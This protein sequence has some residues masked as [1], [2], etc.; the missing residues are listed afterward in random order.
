MLLFGYQWKDLTQYL[1]YSTSSPQDA[2]DC[3]LEENIFFENSLEENFLTLYVAAD[4]CKINFLY[5]YCLMLILLSSKGLRWYI[6]NDVLTR[7]VHGLSYLERLISTIILF[8][9]SLF[10]VYSYRAHYFGFSQAYCGTFFQ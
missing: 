7:S 5:L 10:F 2:F 1:T 8:F 4:D 3:I 6:F 9:F